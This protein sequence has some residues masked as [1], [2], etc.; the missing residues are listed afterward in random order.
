MS[1][2]WDKQPDESTRA[3]ACF[4][5]YRDMGAGY[6]SLAKV[7]EKWGKSISL[8]ERWSSKHKWVERAT[9]YDSQV[10]R[11]ARLQRRTQRREMLGK[12]TDMVGGMVE[13]LD[14]ATFD[15]SSMSAVEQVNALARLT[16]ATAILCD[17]LRTEYDDLP[18]Q[19][20][21]HTGPAGGPLVIEDAR[22]KILAR[23]EIYSRNEAK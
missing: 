4:C 5:D 21:Q 3:Y 11:E 10:D 2:I 19:K 22:Q 14:P 7:G 13:K 18:A 15:P 9:A 20:I 17:E 8:L 16:R 12:G 23:I 1:E 6:R